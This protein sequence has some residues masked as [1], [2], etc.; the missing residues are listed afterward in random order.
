M[1]D[2]SDEEK[3]RI[4]QE[5]KQRLE[6]RKRLEAEEREKVE[7][8]KLLEEAKRLGHR[9]ADGSL[10]IP[11][12]E[13][14]AKASRQ[15]RNVVGVMLLVFG[16]GCSLL[17]AFDPSRRS[18]SS[19]TSTADPNARRKL[20]HDLGPESGLEGRRY[21]FLLHRA[22]VGTSNPL[23]VRVGWDLA[24]LFVESDANGRPNDN[25][26]LRHLVDI[27][28]V[29]MPAPLP[30][31]WIDGRRVLPGLIEAEAWRRTGTEFDLTYRAGVDMNGRQ[32]ADPP[33]EEDLP[34]R[35]AAELDLKV[36]DYFGSA[37]FGTLIGTE[38]PDQG[39][40]NERP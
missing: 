5:E 25:L 27:H 29:E 6:T 7:Q 32:F 31:R 10:W 17:S 15:T 2:L 13:A 9:N 37:P 11:T 24:V 38:I 23:D 22:V 33:D 1:T 14:K 4:L 35:S 34:I 21:Q 39:P 28:S 26:F 8:E 12:A 19:S 3:E 18:G 40:A 36:R 20:I 16:I 30:S